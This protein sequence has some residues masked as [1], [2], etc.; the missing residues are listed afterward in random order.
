MSN[1]YPA[2]VT[3]HNAPWNQAEPWESEICESCGH[4][5]EVDHR[6]EGE[7]VMTLKR[8]FGVCVLCFKDWREIYLCDGDQPACE[9]WER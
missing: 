3:E 5:I 1:I 9:D 2:G 7:K 6:I 8:S 4:F